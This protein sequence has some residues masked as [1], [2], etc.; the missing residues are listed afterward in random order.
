M[1]S[2]A[3]TLIF[4]G[5]FYLFL[6]TLSGW[7]LY[8]DMKRHNGKGQRYIWG[9]HRGAL[10]FGFMALGLAFAMEK[11]SFSGN[12]SNILAWSLNAGFL[13]ILIG[14]VILGIRRNPNQI[15]NPDFLPQSL[16]GIGDILIMAAT[17][18]ILY[19]VVA[20]FWF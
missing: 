2:A 9:T 19:G 15:T 10:W 14:G 5:V 13:L 3:E 20:A 1:A 16:I 18:I 12:L 17:G 6:G 11:L 8:W 4:G 7:W